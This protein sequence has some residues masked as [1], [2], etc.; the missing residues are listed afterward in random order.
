[1]GHGAALHVRAAGHRVRRLLPQ[2]PQPCTVPQHHGRIASRLQRGSAYRRRCAAGGCRELELLHR[3]SRGYQP[4]RPELLH[5]AAHRHRMERRSELPSERTG[6]AEYHRRPVR[7]CRSAG[8]DQPGLRRLRQRLGARWHA[9]RR[10][11]WLPPQGDHPVPD[12]LGAFLRPGDGRRAPDPGRRGRRRACRW[13]GV[14]Q[15]GAL[16]P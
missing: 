8:V 4:V 7:R 6:A 5:H 12:H 16:W 10:S 14:H 11:A 2:L 3:V 1:M 15:Q 13:A 9:R